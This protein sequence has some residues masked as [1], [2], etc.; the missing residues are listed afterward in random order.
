MNS[1]HD[2]VDSVSDKIKYFKNIAPKNNYVVREENVES[3]TLF[4]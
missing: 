4:I 3:H 2:F 1:I